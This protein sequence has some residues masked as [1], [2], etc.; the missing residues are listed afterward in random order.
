[1][2][3]SRRRFLGLAAGA[4]AA[5][6][7]CSISPSTSTGQLLPSRIALPRPFTVPLPSMP[8]LRPS[9]TDGRDVFD[10]V[11]RPT[12]LEVL[13]G[14]RTDLLTYGGTF[15]G[16]LLETRS[17][18]LAVVR[19]RNALDVPVSV[20]LHGGHTP[21]ASD[22]YPTDLVRPG[23]SRDYV[24]PMRQRAAMLWYHDHRMDFTG[25]QVYRGLLGVHLVRDDEEDV[26]P[27][28]HSDREIVL[29]IVDRSFDEHG[30]L[31]YPSPDAGA[32]EHAHHHVDAPGVDDGHIEGVLG[33]VMLVN[34]A[35]W[36]VLEVDAARY[37]LRLLNG[38]SSR[39][40]DLALDPP[41]TAG[42]MFTQVGSDGGLLATSVKHE[43]LVMAQA[44]RFD[45]L[46]DFSKYPVGTQVTLRNRFGSGPMGAVMRFV[47]ARRSGDDSAP[48]DRLPDRLSEIEPLD[49]TGARVREWSFTRGEVHGKSGWVINGRPFDPEVMAATVPLGETEIWRF[50]TDLHHPVHVHLD[51][52]QII[53]RGTSQGP[54]PFDHGW[55]DTVDVRP[56]EHV[57]VAVRFTDYA[58]RYVIHC[59]NLEHE[60]RMMMAAFATV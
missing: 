36:P 19:H 39:R 59:H 1:M 38:C 20:H 2:T 46:V 11:Q 9:T 41:P 53:G 28:P 52:F 45:V 14:A 15:P 60:D 56:A 43:H 42:A 35:A 16:P 7:G 34:G 12:T 26:L 27:L 44:E 50:R 8:V 57:D 23:E 54:G 24:Y 10:L 55:K 37:R 13:P 3:T 58:G 25:E 32:G 6:A 33:D 22:G 18:R 49:T 48:A 47:V 21:S 30:Q 29:A 5:V 40:L 31:H 4:G 17:G 51:P